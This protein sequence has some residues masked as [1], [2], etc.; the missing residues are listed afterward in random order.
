[1]TPFQ[2]MQ[3]TYMA[4]EGITSFFGSILSATLSS[5]TGRFIRSLASGTPEFH[6]IIRVVQ[7]IFRAGSLF[8]SEF[9]SIRHRRN[10]DVENSLQVRL[11]LQ[12]APNEEAYF[13]IL[14]QSGSYLQY[15]DGELLPTSQAFNCPQYRVKKTISFPEGLRGIIIEPV[16]AR[17]DRMPMMVFQGTDFS[18]IHNVVDDISKNIAEINSSKYQAKLHTELESLA[19]V[20][21]K[22]VHLLGHSY[23]G[24]VA[25][26]LTALY[27][28]LVGR[29]T[30]YNAPGVGEDMVQRY[31]TNIA[32]IERYMPRPDVRAYRHIN[33]VV[34]LIGGAALPTA[35]G[36]NVSCGK[37][38][39]NISFLEAHS[40]NTLS[41]GAP[42]IDNARSAQDIQA[43]AQFAEQNRRYLS[44]AIP[45]FRLFHKMTA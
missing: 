24:A 13:Q 34:S 27:P 45:L 25:Q 22:R 21:G 20:H 40:F 42:C 16:Q 11:G 3:A 26:R 19:T 33:D 39:N 17:P 9:R 10:D 2:L 41:T 5:N 6:R 8:L 14:A 38:K 15:R 12:H 35:P 43:F 44:K 23:G 29:C 18:N 36:F 37:T 28:Q 32:A 4:V 7:E 30:Y 31:Q 1:M